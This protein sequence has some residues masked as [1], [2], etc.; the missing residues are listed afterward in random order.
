MSD[1]QSGKSCCSCIINSVHSILAIIDF[2]ENLQNEKYFNFFTYRK[3]ADLLII[4]GTFFN[5]IF[6]CSMVP[7]SIIIYCC[8]CL[9]GEKSCCAQ[10]C[11]YGWACIMLTLYFIIQLGS[12]AAQVASFIESL[13]ENV[14]ETILL[15]LMYVILGF[16]VLV[17]IFSCISSCCEKSSSETKFDDT[18]RITTGSEN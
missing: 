12:F 3:W 11:A 13:K 5:L 7:L 14:D 16:S 2:F 17:F 10:T 8:V 4:I 9:C 15:I 1:N 6:V 18:S